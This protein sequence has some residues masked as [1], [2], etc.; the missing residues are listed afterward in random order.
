MQRRHFVLAATSILA[1]PA[2][3]RA[4]E[5]R[6]RSEER[7]LADRLP[8]IRDVRQGPD[9]LIYLVTQSEDGGLFRLEPA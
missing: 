8:Y 2:V 3:V 9:E 6:C 1:A 5:A 4:Q 7:L